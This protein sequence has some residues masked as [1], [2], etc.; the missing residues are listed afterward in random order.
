MVGT[1][2]FSIRIREQEPSNQLRAFGD[3]RALLAA[4]NRCRNACPAASSIAL[5]HDNG[6][7]P[8]SWVGRE[9]VCAGAGPSCSTPKLFALVDGEKPQRG[10]ARPG[11]AARIQTSFVQRLPWGTEPA[12]TAVPALCCRLAI[13]ASS[14]SLAT[15][16]MIT[17]SHLVA[18]GIPHRT[19][20]VAFSYVTHARFSL[21]LGTNARLHAPGGSAVAAAR[22]VPWVRWLYCT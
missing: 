22:L 8:R 12:C 17:S 7:T 3:V 4:S 20:P 2:A 21:R 9:Q 16:W 19:G 14:T 6:F 1:A 10:R 18:K 5:V 15:P 11:W 13:E